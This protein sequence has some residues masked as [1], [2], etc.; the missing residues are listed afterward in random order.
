MPAIQFVVLLLAVT[1]SGAYIVA[2]AAHVFAI[3]AQQTASGL[4]AVEWPK[5]PWYDWIGKALHLAWLV[6]FWVVPLGIVLR[7]I[8][9][10]TLAAS[11]TL[12]VGVP[13]GLFWLLVPINLLSSFSAG[14]PW[15]LLRPEVLRRMVRCPAG[16]LGFYLLTAPLC[17][18]GGA[19][20]YA[21]LAHRLFY[22]LPV[23]ATVLFLY[24]RLVGRYA[25]LLGRVR[26]KGA[27]PKVDREV[28]RAAK[29]AKVED[30]WG[31][32]AE[33]T[34]KERPKKKKKKQAAQVHDPWAIPEDEP[35]DTERAQTPVEGY[36]LAEDGPGPKPEGRP[37]Q[38]PPPVEGY[39]LNP[40]GPPPLP[41]EVPLD[42]APPIEP[43]RTLSER[44]T[45]L[46]DRPL[47]DGVFSFPWYSSNLGVWGLLTLLFLGWGLLY[48]TM[49]A[50]GSGLGM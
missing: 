35:G 25:R 16:T 48:V 36:G 11:A 2:Y 33:G 19:A 50:V 44:E 7:V 31:V 10:E 28:R 5:D 37:A 3:V 40:E 39:D 38:K 32:P 14:S 18:L 8:G 47:V 1:V 41:K 6:V 43:T 42:G 24:A 26:L 20:L 46:P 30:P 29:A 21:T 17:A 45:P 34:K 9:P 27:G 15:V 23:L 13:A 49:R 22:A 12:Y 4:D